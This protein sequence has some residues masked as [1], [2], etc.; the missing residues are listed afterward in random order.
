MHMLNENP[1]ESFGPFQG[2][3]K[4][5]FYLGLFAG[6]AGSAIVALALL[7]SSISSGKSLLPTQA[8][9]TNAPSAVAPTPTPT[10]T[11]PTQPVGGPVKPVD[12]KVDHIIG[13]KNAKVTLIEYSDFECPFCKR[14]FDTMQ[15]VLK[16]YPNDVRIVYRHFPLSFHQN[17]EKEAEASEC[18]NDLGGSVAFWKLHDRIFTDTTSNGTGFALD[19]LGPAA[20]DI[21]LDQ[22]KFQDCLD[23]GKFASRVA[24]DQQ[25][26][27]DAGVQGTPAT[28]VNGKL[29][30]GAVPYDVFKAEI[31]AALKK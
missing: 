10:P 27:S 16:N 30:S 11:Q 14:H 28:F 24:K 4:T 1:S 31:D 8:A 29:I 7:L 2:S 13:A 12:E 5:M 3:P 6:V 25:E 19:K 26:G 20:K 23:S 22:K 9:D 17:A 21:G 15:Q 18:A